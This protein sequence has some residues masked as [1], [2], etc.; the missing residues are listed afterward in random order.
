[1]L[2]HRPCDCVV[3]H[4]GHHGHTTP[5]R[6]ES[7]P[8]PSLSSRPPRLLPPLPEQGLPLLHRTTSRFFGSW[9]VHNGLLEVQTRPSGDVDERFYTNPSQLA[10][11]ST[12]SRMLK[13]EAFHRFGTAEEA[14]GECSAIAA[15]EASDGL[16]NFL[17]LN[18][19]KKKY[20]LGVVSA[21][22]GKALKEGRGGFNCEAGK[23]ITG[24][25]G[26][27][28]FVFYGGGVCYNIYWV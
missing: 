22:L 19:P 3:V 27:A 21:E 15:N 11:Y 10:E 24:R 18:L 23:G 8:S 7:R 4:H 1:M 5:S 28:A 14:L 12:F 2:C 16:V 25:I 26:G 17:E 9:F 13:M 20:S 6:S